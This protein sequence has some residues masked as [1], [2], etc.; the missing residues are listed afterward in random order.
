MK[1]ESL[2]E[3]KCKFFPAITLQYNS[4]LLH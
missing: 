4:E 3:P 1:T 2:R